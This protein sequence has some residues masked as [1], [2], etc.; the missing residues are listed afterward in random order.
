MKIELVINSADT[1]ALDELRQQVARLRDAG[2]QVRARL[3]F[4]NGDASRFASE[5]VREGA[6]LVI[7]A[8]GDGTLNEVVNGLLPAGRDLE[9][10]PLPRLGIV[11]LGTAN[12]FANYLEIPEDIEAA[13]NLAVEGPETI[14]D[15]ATVN[16]RY[17][18]NV[19]SGGIGAEATEEASDRTKRLLGSLAYVITGIRKF[20]LLTPMRGRFSGGGE[21]IFDGD[22]LFFAV[23][24]GTRTGG[25]IRVTPLADVTDGLL[26]LCI[27]EDV[28]R[29]EFLRLLPDIRAG[30]HLENEH[31]TYRKVRELIV[32][33]AGDLSVNVDGEP[34]RGAVLE[35]TVQAGALRV[36]G[37]PP[38]PE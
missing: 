11:P 1:G 18:L 12:D 25:G 5:A 26:D 37:T 15:V 8:G 36:S 6:D 38:A 14:L 27:V 34:I 16:G 9:A 20:A 19:S 21:V 23:G 35:Y 22:F 10:R 32:E 2:H 30:K 24:N 31:V 4:E 17:Y 33:P 29:A 13:V 3:T 28:D 7:A